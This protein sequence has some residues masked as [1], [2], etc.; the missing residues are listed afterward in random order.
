[1]NHV[2]WNTEAGGK[3]LCGSAK[4]IV[5]DDVWP[6]Q[7]GARILK[8]INTIIPKCRIPLRRCRSTKLAKL[9]KEYSSGDA[10]AYVVVYNEEHARYARD[11]IAAGG[12]NRYVVHVM[13]LLEPVGLRKGCTP[14]FDHLIANASKVITINGELADE[15]GRIRNQKSLVIPPCC[16]M[17]SGFQRTDIRT[18]PLRIAIVGALYNPCHTGGETMLSMLARVVPKVANLLSI[19]LVSTSETLQRF[20]EKLRPY[21]EITGHL[22]PSK[23]DD[24]LRSC[25]ISCVTMTYEPGSIFRYSVPSRVA[26]YLAFGLP[27][28]AM[29]RPN[30]AMG[31]FLGRMDNKF[32]RLVGSDNEL[33]AALLFYAENP[34]AL[35][36]GSTLA[37]SYA[38]RE[39]STERWREAID[40][41]ID[42]G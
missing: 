1:M 33:L 38:K 8:W 4:H 25:D 23:L 19:Q 24:L 14:S 10:L 16:S 11:I 41:A 9:I 5:V 32:V 39:F 15:V 6:L 2:F 18:G 20:P 40:R 3:S 34:E 36:E 42:I 21:I 35:A 26:D 17:P 12:W 13:D 31:T 30:T 37:A 22:T 28:I 7:R 29:V 27:T